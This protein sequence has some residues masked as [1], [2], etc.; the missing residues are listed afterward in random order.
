MA[1]L[2]RHLLRIM[3]VAGALIAAPYGISGSGDLRAN[4][5]SCTD[6]TGTCCREYASICNAG[7]G[8]HQDYYYKAEGKCG[9]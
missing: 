7:G 4:E 9:F 2:A 6:N 8:D 5:A 1:N 3:L